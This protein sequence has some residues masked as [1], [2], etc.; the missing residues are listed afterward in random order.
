MDVLIVKGKLCEP[1][2]YFCKSCKQLR[3]S[4]VEEDKCA[5]CGGDIIKGKMFEL[6][7][8]KLLEEF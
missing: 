4:Y 3:L 8:E 5:N 7:K 6:D 2:E 1:Y